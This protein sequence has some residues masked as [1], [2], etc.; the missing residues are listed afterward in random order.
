MRLPQ[1]ALHLRSETRSEA[2]QHG[3]ELVFCHGSRVHPS[4]VIN[5]P[6]DGLFRYSQRSLR[7]EERRLCATLQP[8]SEKTFRSIVTRFT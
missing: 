5:L 6:V 7:G 8:M 1:K 4:H 2:P 3:R